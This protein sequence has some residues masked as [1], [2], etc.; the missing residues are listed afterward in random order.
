M[1]QKQTTISIRR[2]PETAEI[3]RR[4]QAKLGLYTASAVIAVAVRH[5]A[6]EYGVP[7][8]TEEGEHLQNNSAE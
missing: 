5:L 6:K 3:I 1:A 4:L 2:S 7:I 8:E